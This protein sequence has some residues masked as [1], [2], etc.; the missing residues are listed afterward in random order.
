MLQ[1][2]WNIFRC[3]GMQIQ[4]IANA[5]HLFGGQL[6]RFAKNKMAIHEFCQICQYHKLLW[7]HN[8]KLPTMIV[9]ENCRSCVGSFPSTAMFENLPSLFMS[10]G[11]ISAMQ[12]ISQRWSKSIVLCELA[13]ATRH[14]PQTV[15]VYE[16][17]CEKL[18]SRVWAT[19]TQKI[20]RQTVARFISARFTCSGDFWVVSPF[21]S[22]SWF[23]ELM[24]ERIFRCVGPSQAKIYEC[25]LH[26]S[27]Q[28]R[29]SDSTGLFSRSSTLFHCTSVLHAFSKQVLLQMTNLHP[30]CKN[31][32]SNK[33]RAE[34]NLT[35]SDARSFGFF[36]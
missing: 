7:L 12:N 21:H 27:M 30:K 1:H 4:P 8:R 33:K 32:N 34:M 28:S 11:L 36:Y 5:E 16:N 15:S 6:I 10:G 17:V 9:S 29:K 31:Q 26:L 25:T 35:M 13:Q 23:F 19:Q 24:A 18:T 14:T 22:R 3:Q 2:I 20:K